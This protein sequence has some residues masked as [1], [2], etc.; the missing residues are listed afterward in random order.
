M[1]RL[2]PLSRREAEGRPAEEAGASAEVCGCHPQDGDAVVADKVLAIQ[3]R[4][5]RPDGSGG[6]L[7]ASA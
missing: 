4:S 1:L 5:F 7:H 3:A 6:S 2:L